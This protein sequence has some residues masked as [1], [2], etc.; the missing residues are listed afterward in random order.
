MNEPWSPIL[1]GTPT[2][3]GT[4]FVGEFELLEGEEI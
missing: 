2:V 1:V 3:P 4:E